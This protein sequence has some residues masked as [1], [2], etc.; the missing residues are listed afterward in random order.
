MGS[1]DRG[2]AWRQS[3]NIF[4]RAFNASITDVNRVSENEHQLV[5]R[6]DGR[7]AR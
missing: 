2:D 7:D 4:E 6:V 3:E 5:G 1:V